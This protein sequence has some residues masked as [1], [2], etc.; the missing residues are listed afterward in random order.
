MIILVIKK[1]LIKDFVE[2]N[3]D[4]HIKTDTG[5]SFRTYYSKSVN[6]HHVCLEET[7]RR[8]GS[9]KATVEQREGFRRAPAGGCW[10]EEAGAAD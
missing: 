5:S 8:Q 10:C 6:H 3:E 7:Q 2:V 1:R 9:G 4:H